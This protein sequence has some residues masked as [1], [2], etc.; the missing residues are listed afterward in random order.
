MRVNN[1]SDSPLP[2]REAW[3]GPF[4]CSPERTIAISAAEVGES[5]QRKIFPLTSPAQPGDCREISREISN[6]IEVMEE[7]R[8]RK[9]DECVVNTGLFLNSWHWCL[10]A[11]GGCLEGCSS[12]VLT[13]DWVFKISSC[14]RLRPKELGTDRCVLLV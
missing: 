3:K 1:A 4:P 11:E 2:A 12:P 8:G 7:I 9:G 10:A 14:P 13:A 6:A 5:P